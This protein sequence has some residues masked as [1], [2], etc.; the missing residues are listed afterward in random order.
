METAVITGASRGLGAAVARLFGR[1][2]VHVGICA[3]DA[4]E[5]EAVAADVREAGGSATTRRADVRDEF[6]LERLMEATAREGGALD[7]VVANAGVY[8]GPASATPVSEESYAA[9]D[10]HVRTN[11]RGVF[12]TIQESLPHLAPDARVLVPSGR[13]ARETQSG[14][15][16]YAVSKAVA[17]A[18]ARQFAAALDY[19]VG[20]LDVGQLATDLSG[21][22]GRAP[23]DIAPMVHWAATEAPP[24]EID[25]A[26][27][28]L[29][30]WRSATR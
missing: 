20:V 27:T 16:T 23:D 26:V 8:H 6:D 11:G 1:E 17:E 3:R 12:A 24:A 22:E 5:V 7:C 10:D 25:G 9:F 4:D 30:D 15:G 14:Y 2:G 28:D 19:P 13:V 18:V 21:A 29:R